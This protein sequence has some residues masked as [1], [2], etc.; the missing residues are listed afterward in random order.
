MEWSVR[1]EGE[2]VLH[3]RGKCGGEGGE[4]GLFS[5]HSECG[6]PPPEGAWHTG[7]GGRTTAEA[8]WMGNLSSSPS[9]FRMLLFF[10]FCRCAWHSDE[11]A[12]HERI[13]G[14][15]DFG[16]GEFRGENF[17]V[18]KSGEIFPLAKFLQRVTGEYC[19]FRH[20]Q[21]CTKQREG[22]RDVFFFFATCGGCAR[23]ALECCVALGFE[24]KNCHWSISRERHLPFCCR[25]THYLCKQQTCK[26]VMQNML[27]PQMG[28]FV[29]MVVT[30]RACASDRHFFCF[31][32]VTESVCHCCVIFVLVIH[33]EPT[34][35]Y[36]EPSRAHQE[37]PG[38]IH[39]PPGNTRNHREPTRKYQEPSRAHQEIPGTIQSPPGNT[40]SHPEPT[41]KYQE[42][43][44][45][46]QEITGTIQRPPENNRIL[47]EPSGKCQE[48]SRAHQEIPGTIH[49]PPGNTRN[50]PQ[51]TRKYQDPSR[52]HQKIPG[53]IQSPPGN[54]R[55]HPQPTRKYQEP[56]RAHQKIT[57]S[58][59]SPPGNAKNHP[60]RTR[61]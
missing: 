51:P 4:V 40:K 7:C 55:N 26:P 13:Q 18:K 24:K 2:G 27:H 14:G 15:G 56:S 41:K 28:P 54:T 39:S 49:S 59:Q 22:T 57:G 21:C 12:R 9:S 50:H 34:R 46:H 8:R 42:P 52:A 47:S 31:L 61:K 6:R 43:S 25:V 20:A 19:E 3:R 38:T 32:A 5:R 36:Q 45:A 16:G 37:V 60:E 53:T 58:F 30:C 17:A 29:P 1:G 33:P 23:N 11:C 35:K 48:P 10:Q 44:R